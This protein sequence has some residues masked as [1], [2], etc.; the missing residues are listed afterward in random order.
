MCDEGEDPR[1]QAGDSSS[2]PAY[3]SKSS[4]PA[5]LARA[6]T[7]R[8]T[9]TARSWCLIS[10]MDVLSV[11]RVG[12]DER[13][14][15][16][17]HNRGSPAPLAKPKLRIMSE[18]GSPRSY[19]TRHSVAVGLGDEQREMRVTLGSHPDGTAWGPQPPA[20]A[21]GR[22]GRPRP[23][24]LAVA[25]TLGHIHDDVQASGSLGRLD[26]GSDVSIAKHGAASETPHLG[27]TS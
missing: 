13:R 24:S 23:R 21:S 27:P 5:L 22:D 4:A 14:A 9:R 2:R 20:Y 17:H 16:R 15:A 6:R 18:I 3:Q 8:G 12:A 19:A 1:A 11:L 26:F 25:K 7:S 10:A